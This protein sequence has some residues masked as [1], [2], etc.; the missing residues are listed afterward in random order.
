[1]T[2]KCKIC[3]NMI[4][5][6]E[7]HVIEETLDTISPLID[8]W[9][10]VDTGSNDE[11]PQ[12][13]EKYFAVRKIPGELH[14]REWRNFGHNR[15]EALK[16]CRGKCEYTWVVDADD[17]MI[18]DPDLSS[19]AEDSYSLKFGPDFLYWRK[20][21][22]RSALDWK[23]VGVVHE[24][25]EC[26]QPASHARLEGDYHIVSRRL[27]ARNRDPKKYLRDV[28]LLEEAL[29]RNPDCPRSTFYLAQSHFDNRD[30]VRALQWYRK[31]VLLDGWD[32]EV[33]Y[34]KL[35]IAECLER[36]GA[37]FGE[38]SGAYLDCW[39]YRPGRAEPLYHLARLCRE[40]K[41]Y[42]AGYLYAKAG[43]DIPFPSDDTLFV[44][45]SIYDWRLKDE[46]SIHAFFTGRFT[47]SS[48]VLKEVL[49]ST[50]VPDD[51][52]ARLEENL[53]L[54]KKRPGPANEE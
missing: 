31:R 37:S 20:Q 11:T 10:I 7:A 23:Y 3:L 49:A 24:Y 45:V 41:K 14:F 53:R 44:D 16:L 36:S 26:G 43:V 8:Y 25:P 9:V 39:E 27:G 29:A 32:E 33:Y 22:F 15:T 5:R 2:S 42:R 28:R 18:G 52:I 17:L 38:V 12:V 1:M 35:R 19:L 13:I 46:L 4:V 54:A 51:H 40:Q 34:S 50:H 30:P 21:I 48:A 6:D 47:E